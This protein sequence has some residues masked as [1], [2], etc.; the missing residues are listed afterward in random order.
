MPNVSLSLPRRGAQDWMSH[1]GLSSKSHKLCSC[2]ES[3]LVLLTV[4]LT[5]VWL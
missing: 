1:K 3:V 4:V 2:F 5:D